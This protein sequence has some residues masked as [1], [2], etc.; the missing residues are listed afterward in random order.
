MNS[1]YLRVQAGGSQLS[2]IVPTCINE[3]TE[4]AFFARMGQFL[5]DEYTELY[6]SLKATHQRFLEIHEGVPAAT[7]FENHATSSMAQSFQDMEKFF[8]GTPSTLVRG[9]CLNVKDQIM[10]GDWDF[11]P[12]VNEYAVALREDGSKEDIGEA[13]LTYFTA[14]QVQEKLDEIKKAGPDLSSSE[15]SKKDLGILKEVIKK[16]KTYD[17]ELKDQATEILTKEDA[18]QMFQMN[19]ERWNSNAIMA[20]KVAEVSLKDSGIMIEA[21][22][23]PGKKVY[24]LIYKHGFPVDSYTQVLPI[25]FDP[26]EK[27]QTLTLSVN[28]AASSPAAIFCK[29]ENMAEKP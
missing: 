1:A 5:F 17:G 25:Y 27:P 29:N 7:F 10:K 14:K 9:V 18:I 6:G 13:E 28:Y 23:E 19:L 16:S 21:K 12:I 11:L 20:A 26:K 8:A 22:K 4:L 15:I 24:S 3:K 2:S